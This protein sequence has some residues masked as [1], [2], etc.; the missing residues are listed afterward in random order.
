[1]TF[2]VATDNTSPDIKNN[3]ESRKV[4]CKSRAKSN[5][6]TKSKKRSKSKKSAKTKG[7][8][9]SLNKVP[10][11]FERLSNVTKNSNSQGNGMVIVK[12]L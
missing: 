12:Y 1:M 4:K 3:V 10:S 7:N 2:A 8:A 11:V 5:S 9:K 6:R